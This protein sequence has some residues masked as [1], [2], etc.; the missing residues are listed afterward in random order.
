MLSGNIGRNYLI[1]TERL[2]QY[3]VVETHWDLRREADD[4]AGFGFYFIAIGSG[5]S[6]GG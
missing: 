5:F 6:M 2:W 4:E 1:A 3:R